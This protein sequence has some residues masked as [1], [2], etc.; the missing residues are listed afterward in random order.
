MALYAKAMF[1]LLESVDGGE[2]AG[3]AAG[4]ESAV[5]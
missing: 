3:F 2:A 4:E 5:F 1:N